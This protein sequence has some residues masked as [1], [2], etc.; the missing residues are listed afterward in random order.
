MRQLREI[1]SGCGRGIRAPEMRL[2][3]KSGW[4]DGKG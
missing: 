4:E 1:C 2:L 3:S